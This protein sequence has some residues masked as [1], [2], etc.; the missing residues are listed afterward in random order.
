MMG[1]CPK[2]D[3]DTSSE[4]DILAALLYISSQL[5]NTRCKKILLSLCAVDHEKEGC[6]DSP[7]CSIIRDT[8]CAIEWR[9]AENVFNISEPSFGCCSNGSRQPENMPPLN[10]TNEFIL[11]CDSICILSCE[12][13]S[14]HTNSITS[15]YTKLF[16]FT[17]NSLMLGA[18]VVI[19][20]AVVKR[21]TM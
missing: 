13:F 1:S 18:A 15:A 20:L 21:K 4:S 14:Q 3:D 7:Q 19:L 6:I 16:I 11:I 17:G 10:C 12:K 9:L 5:G 2:Q 8:V